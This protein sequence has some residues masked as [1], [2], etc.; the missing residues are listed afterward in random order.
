[1]RAQG[2][3]PIRVCISGAAGK[4]GT[5]MCRALNG[6]EGIELVGTVDR[7]GSGAKL[8]D[9]AGLRNTD[10]VIE[11]K[12]GAALDRCRPQVLLDFTHPGAAADH[13]VSALKRKIA[14]VIGTSGLTNSDLQEIAGASGE[15]QTP[16]MYVPNFAIGAVL[17]MKFSQMAAR[18]MP[19]VEIVEMHH[20]SKADAPSGTAKRTAEIIAG[21]MAEKPASNNRELIRVEGVRGGQVQG[22]RVHSV[23]LL[24]LVAH[25]M[26]LFGGPGETLTI[27]HD[28]FD[29]SSFVQGV[30]LAIREVWN[31]KGLVVGLDSLID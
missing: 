27:R 10:L 25:Q 16:A 28:S 24:G 23:R 12:L 2:N 20:D 30:K 3:E 8:S 4:M 21:A 13:A 5:V 7:E 26:V 29:R 19:D 15:Y 14:P 11:D 9:V 22:V 1:M 18:W 6:A 17:M 31:Q